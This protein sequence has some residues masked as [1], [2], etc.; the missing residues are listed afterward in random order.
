MQKNTSLPLKLT[1]LFTLPTSFVLSQS[2][3]LAFSSDGSVAG[4]ISTTGNAAIW[5][6]PLAGALDGDG[7]NS[8][9]IGSTFSGLVFALSSDG[10]V[11]AGSKLSG[12]DGGAIWEKSSSSWQEVY[13]L[14]GS[15]ISALSSDG[16]IAAGVDNNFASIWKKSSGGWSQSYKSVNDSSSL[17]ALSADGSIAAGKDTNDIASVWVSDNGASWSSPTKKPVDDNAFLL[18][19][20]SNGLIAAGYKGDAASPTPKVYVTNNNWADVNSYSLG[21]PVNYTNGAVTSLSDDGQKAVGFGQKN[22][23]LS[24]RALLWTSNAGDWSATQAPEILPFDD[25]VYQD[26]QARSI[27]GDGNVV[28]GIV[29]KSNGD[30]FPYIWVLSE[31]SQNGTGI[32]AIHV[33]NA[34]TAITESLIGQQESL[35]VLSGDMDF[36][37]RGHMSVMSRESYSFKPRFVKYAMSSVPTQAQWSS[38]VSFYKQK[39]LA[40]MLLLDTSVQYGL[41]NS[42]RPIMSLKLGQQIKKD[43]DNIFNY[44]GAQVRVSLGVPYSM[45]SNCTLQPQ[46]ARL[47]SQ[48]NIARLGGLTD[49]EYAH[50]DTKFYGTAYSLLGSYRL[51]EQLQMGLVIKHHLLRRTAFSESG[52]ATPISYSEHKQRHTQV[53]ASYLYTKSLTSKV[54][55]ALMGKVA[56]E[57]DSHFDD[58]VATSTTFPGMSTPVAI[59]G[60]QRDNLSMGLC[61]S[62]S[63]QV[64]KGH[65]LSLQFSVSQSALKNSSSLWALS[66]TYGL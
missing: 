31:T 7:G 51:D 14:A 60:P 52:S 12:T 38:S 21:L 48:A 29:F 47:W 15:T 8:L 42:V 25:T 23:G 13:F 3:I 9:Q 1:L 44:E 4:G 58:I 43:K 19:L 30:T 18:A 59:A 33:E 24:S 64:D 2:A 39:Q 6:S 46:V 65:T 17:S 53:E 63:Y 11:A 56:Y 50:G 54:K 55:G 22:A 28:G 61:S 36:A 49:T 34:Q 45:N 5:E 20:S 32:T 66:V 10:T 41:R 37:Q 35:M 27:S 57:L 62:V 26:S 16:Q 40:P